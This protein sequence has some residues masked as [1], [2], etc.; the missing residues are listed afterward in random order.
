M[1]IFPYPA[2]GGMLV[3]ALAL[4]L[5]C[6]RKA[7]EPPSSTPTAPRPEAGVDELLKNVHWLGHASFRLNGEKV[8]YIDPYQLKTTQPADIILITHGHYDHCSPDDVRKIR[9]ATTAIVATGDCASKLGGEVRV[10]KAG[11]VIT[12]QGVSIEAVPA[13]NIGKSYHPKEAGGLG[14]IVTLNGVRIYHAGDTDHTPEMDAVR[15]DVALLPVGGKY[16]MDA[17]EA[18]EA[19]NAMKPKVAVPMHWGNIVGSKADAERF[20]QLCQ[21]PVRILE[22]EED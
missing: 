16:T 3:L 22:R 7:S 2:M 15:A 12:L 8:V 1:K 6:G 17:R 21:V 19:V 9:Q 5:S 4:S 11:E 14:Y 13:Y 18:A 20:A 10:I